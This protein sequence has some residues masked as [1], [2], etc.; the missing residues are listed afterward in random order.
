MNADFANGMTSLVPNDKRKRWSDKKLAVV[1][2]LFY[3][4]AI[5]RKRINMEYQIYLCI[6][7]V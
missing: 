5:S 1:P 2:F 4:H 6:F 3:I 7:E